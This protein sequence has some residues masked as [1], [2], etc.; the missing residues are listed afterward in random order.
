V[1]SMCWISTTRENEVA[2][3][4]ICRR[5]SAG[6][7]EKKAKVPSSGE[8]YAVTANLSKKRIRDLLARSHAG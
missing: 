3:C 2:Y 5:I 6:K 7:V 4:H 8:S 1:G